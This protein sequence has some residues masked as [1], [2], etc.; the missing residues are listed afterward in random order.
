L[1]VLE[2]MHSSVPNK[3]R[4]IVGLRWYGCMGEGKK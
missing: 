3:S 1:V 2:E 4:L